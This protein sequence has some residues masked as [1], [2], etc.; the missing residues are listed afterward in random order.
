M[1]DD[2]FASVAESE[3]VEPTPDFSTFPQDDQPH[4]ADQVNP[5]LWPYYL[6]FR[7]R[8]FFIHFVLTAVPALTVLAAWA[9]GIASTI[10][11]MERNAMRSDQ[12]VNEAMLGSWSV[13][14]VVVATGGILSGG[15]YWL[16]GGWWYNKRLRFCGVHKGPMETMLGRRVYLYA[17]LT[18]ALPTI[19]M[20][21]YETIKYPTPLDTFGGN[22]DYW[23]YLLFMIF[24]FWSI[25]TSYAGATTCFDLKRGKAILWF[26]VLPG[27]VYGLLF[28]VII[29]IA[30]MPYI[31]F[32]ESP[33]LAS[34][35]T[36]RGQ[37]MSFHYPGNWIKEP[38]DPALP[39]G[40]ECVALEPP[41]DAYLSFR[42][43]D[44]EGSPQTLFENYRDELRPSLGDLQPQGDM[45]TELGPFKGV[46]R[47]FET[48]IND[49]PCEVRLFI[50]P[51][52]NDQVLIV[53]QV[54]HTDH[55]EL[56]DEGLGLVHRTWVWR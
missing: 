15:L 40:E 22:D 49:Q 10:N 55:A 52:P 42:T 23:L 13:Y 17:A 48:T 45:L 44:Y 43:F 30:M 12:T 2:E 32:Y 1:Q 38:P 8:L 14:W 31:R 7:P 33:D 37:M 35:N 53:Y 3:S 4:P 34:A 51:R 54:I 20:T 27:I 9:Y 5:A 21:L 46:G 56:V 6:F 39:A 29:V 28:G 24:P 11:R 18:L 16:F 25:W 26:I 36:Y 47:V 41:Q 50:C 19:G